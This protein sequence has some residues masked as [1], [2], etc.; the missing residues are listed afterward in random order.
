MSNM[1][2]SRRALLGTVL[3]GTLALSLPAVA[4]TPAESF[5]TT[6]GNN[7]IE[8]ARNGSVSNFRDVLRA[9]ADVETI[10]V[11]SLGSYRKSLDAGRKAEYFGLVEAY[12]ARVFSENATRLAG[13]SLEVTGSQEAADSVIVKSLLKYED[14]RSVAVTWRLVKRGGAYK[15]FD[16]N[17]DG[18]WLATTQKTNF[19]S[20]LKQNKGDLGALLTYLKQ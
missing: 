3:L 15:I 1:S 16:V 9:S 10:A 2:L 19:V 13:N 17:V 20:V 11:F 14:G 4:A 8:A 5:V 18:I 7:V 12:I 6:V